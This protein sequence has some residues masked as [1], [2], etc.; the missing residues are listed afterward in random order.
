MIE[1]KLHLTTY[2]IVKIHFANLEIPDKVTK[3]LDIFGHVD[4]LVNNGGISLRSE[5]LETKIGE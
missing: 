3:V 4:I 2:K 1:K 5:A